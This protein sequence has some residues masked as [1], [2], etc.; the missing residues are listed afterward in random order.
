MSDLT[1]EEKVPDSQVISTF[2][3]TLLAYSL[4]YC[5]HSYILYSNL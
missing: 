5:F 4:A 2:I 1:L 3:R